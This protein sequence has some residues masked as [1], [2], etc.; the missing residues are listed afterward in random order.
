MV[1]ETIAPHQEKDRKG[2][3]NHQKVIAQKGALAPTSSTIFNAVEFAF[4][5]VSTDVY[6][7]KGFHP[8][9]MMLLSESLKR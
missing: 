9:V 5:P 4:F 8:R 2:K 3:C 1:M 7:F 6:P